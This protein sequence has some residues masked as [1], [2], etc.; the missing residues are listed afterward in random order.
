LIGSKNQWRN[1]M[2]GTLLFAFVIL[3]W[4]CYMAATILMEGSIFAAMR[5]YV[6]SRAETNRLFYWIRDMLGCLMCTATEVAL[7]TIG[8][9]GF[10]LGFHYRF[11]SHAVGIMAGKPVALPIGVELVL[12]FAGAFAVALAIA[13]EAWGIKNV[14][15]N[16]DEKFLRLREEFREQEAELLER[17]AHLEI[18]AGSDGK[19]DVDFDLS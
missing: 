7:W 10:L 11:A 5:M 8:I 6:S 19:D 16:R 17:I 1:S 14:M 15:E 2:L 13:G 9:A 4:A 12:S 18:R 3:G